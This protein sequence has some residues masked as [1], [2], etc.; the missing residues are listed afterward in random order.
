MR[1]PTSTANVAAHVRGPLVAASFAFVGT[2]ELSCTWQL[3]EP[4]NHTNVSH[5]GIPAQRAWQ[6]DAD[7]VV[8]TA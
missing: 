1:V 5:C 7:A 8:D 4:E 3:L 2:L 6:S